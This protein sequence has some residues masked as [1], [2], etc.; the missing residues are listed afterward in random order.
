MTK[1]WTNASLGLKFG[2]TKE[3]FCLCPTMNIQ[4]HVLLLCIRRGILH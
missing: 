3:A 2:D 1:E 4:S